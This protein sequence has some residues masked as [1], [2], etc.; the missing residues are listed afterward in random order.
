MSDLETLVKDLEK[1]L[2]A[3]HQPA[4]FSSDSEKI[5]NLFKSCENLLRFGGYKTLEPYVRNNSKIVKKVSDLL[6]RFNLLRYKYFASL[7]TNK[8]VDYIDQK[9]ISNFVKARQEALGPEV[10]KKIVLQHCADIIDTI[11]ENLDKFNF[12]DAP[13][14]YILGQKKCGWITEKALEIMDAKYKE[15]LDNQYNKVKAEATTYYSDSDF[16]LLGD[17]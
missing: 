1:V 15:H 2:A 16:G 6:D 14:P 10:S 7:P 4:L 11:F 8:G 5:K 12:E 17:Y 9:H 3:Y 13:R